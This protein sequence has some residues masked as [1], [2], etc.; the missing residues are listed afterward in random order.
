MGT[1]QTAGERVS[2][3]LDQ[4]MEL[5]EQLDLPSEE[6]QPIMDRAR[7][8][9][10][11]L[12]EVFERSQGRRQVMSK[13]EELL[14]KLKQQWG[15]RLVYHEVEG[16][17]RWEVP[18]DVSV[19][20]ASTAVVL[21]QD[22][23]TTLDKYLEVSRQTPRSRTEHEKLQ[24]LLGQL[25]RHISETSVEIG[26][27]L[28]VAQRLPAMSQPSPPAPAD[29]GAKPGSGGEDETATARLPASA[30]DRTEFP[31]RV[32]LG[33]A[34]G[35]PQTAKQQQRRTEVE[36]GPAA[37]PPLIEPRVTVEEVDPDRILNLYRQLLTI[38]DYAAA[39]W[40]T[41]AAHTLGLSALPPPW[42]LKAYVLGC[43]TA[44][45]PAEIG[46]QWS[47]IIS[48]HPNVIEDSLRGNRVDRG[49]LPLIVLGA[50][51]GPAL[52]GWGPSALLWLHETKRMAVWASDPIDGIMS[53]ARSGRPLL[54]LDPASWPS[55]SAAEAALR[56]R[57]WLE[58]GSDPGAPFQLATKVLRYFRSQKSI[59]GQLASLIALDDPAS[60]DRVRQLYSDLSTP[61]KQ[62]ELI[63]EAAAALASPSMRRTRIQGGLR[64][65]CLSA[66]RDI[67]E[68]ARAWIVATERLT[69]A[70]TAE[71]DST[72][73]TQAA[74]T[75][76]RELSDAFQ[77]RDSSRPQGTG[78]GLHAF[79]HAVETL[80]RY[81]QGKGP[82]H[83]HL[84]SWL[85]V[86]QQPVLVLD[87][88]PLLDEEA[89]PVGL[90]RLQALEFSAKVSSPR[91]LD[92]LARQHM[93]RLNFLA[94][95][96][97]LNIL[98]SE[99]PGA[100]QPLLEELESKRTE[101]TQGIERQIS[102]LRSAVERET[103]QHVLTE[104]QRS[105]LIGEA[106]E[107]LKGLRSKG[108]RL[109]LV[110]Q[111]VEALHKQLVDAR[112]T[113]KE[114]LAS[115][116]GQL[117][118]SLANDGTSVTGEELQ[119]VTSALEKAEL[120]LASDDLAVADERIT[121][122]EEAIHLGKPLVEVHVRE[123]ESILERFLQS[124]QAL[125]N[126]LE[127]DRPYTVRREIER[128]LREPP[129]KRPQVAGIDLRDVPGA[130]TGE[131]MNGLQAF[132]ELKGLQSR[133][134][135]QQAIAHH[136]CTLLEYYGFRHPHVR[137]RVPH[138]TDY[139]HATVQMSDG[140]LSPLSAFGSERQG[141]Y[142]VLL[143]WNRPSI[144][145]LEQIINELHLLGKA[146]IVIYL[147]RA[148]LR[149]RAE[150]SQFCHRQN[151]TAMFIDELVTFFV[152]SQRE[153]RLPGTVMLGI[154]WGFNNP[155]V[156]F[157]R[158]SV[159][160]EIFKGRKEIIEEL[161]KPL[162]SA[163]IYGGR[164]LG[165]SAI[166]RS[167]E[168]RA[169]EDRSHGH[170]LYVCYLDILN[171]GSPGS[172]THPQDVW[173]KIRQW[174]VEV[175]LL[176]RRVSER[177]EKVHEK[178]A[179][180]FTSDPLLRVYVLLDEADKFLTADAAYEFQ[181]V[182]QLKSLMD[183]T[184]GRF[185]VILSGLHSVQRF[186]SMPNQPLLHFGDAIC[187]G[188]LE[189]RAAVELIRVPLHALGYRFR[190]EDVVYRILS[191]TNYHPALIQ[192]FC[193]ELVR[194]LAQ[195]RTFVAQSDPRY[196]IT[197]EDV[198]QVYRLP[199]VRRV[200]KDRFEATLV[201]DASFE[202]IVYSMI[203]FQL[204]EPDGYRKEFSV[205]EVQELV[206]VTWPQ[207]FANVRHE[208]LRA[209]LDELVGL[210]VLL[211]TTHGSYRLRNANV[212]RALGFMEEIEKRVD[213]FAD[214][215]APVPEY[216]P[217]TTVTL[218][219]DEG[220][221]SPLTM[222]Q[223][224]VLCQP[225]TGVCLVFGS[226]ALG[227][228]HLP[229]ALRQFAGKDSAGRTAI[230]DSVAEA[231]PEVVTG[232]SLR[233]WL[234]S[235]WKQLQGN[236]LLVVVQADH[237]TDE[238]GLPGVVENLLRFVDERQYKS[239]NRL[240][241]LVIAFNSRATVGWMRDNPSQVKQIEN[242]AAATLEARP[243]SGG[244]MERFIRS[245]MLYTREIHLLLEEV[246]GGWPWLWAQ[247]MKTLRE[248]FGQDL[249]NVNPRASAE[250][251][252]AR[253]SGADGDLSKAFLDAT[254]LESVP[255]GRTIVD[256]IQILDGPPAE[257]LTPELVFANGPGCSRE[258]FWA[259]VESMLRLGLLRKTDGR[260]FADAV[261]AR[262]LGYRR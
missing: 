254:G 250:E 4:L 104:S 174:F 78:L 133:G 120:A 113:R 42:L 136:L 180:R 212:V 194:V 61:A 86:L 181:T 131:I 208:H 170:N 218:V 150:W 18:A 209:L 31:A 241:R 111:S 89:I 159:P 125:F 115:R 43:L 77:S 93:C 148:T 204:K 246:I 6:L 8:L 117:R 216:D 157:A 2:A 3:L 15:E 27:L 221:C 256:A 182:R 102:D 124:E 229:A 99:N 236:R 147:G 183:M 128:A 127:Q 230:Y 235:R 151:L 60:V 67:A 85:R 192:H 129:G 30:P 184:Q 238:R 178:L 227:I 167:I 34:P 106:E 72:R 169:R 222:K 225:R 166:L 51:V 247:L 135:T 260:I 94:A 23:A 36:D 126:A 108:G 203:W 9:V 5:A 20:A 195:R 29:G 68:I 11:K 56:A 70:S 53:L 112:R 119:K 245:A 202:A 206:S 201:L 97:A 217:E 168:R 75:L 116:I 249:T 244:V 91:Q 81:L 114:S 197:V 98:D 213:G 74:L 101:A 109:D 90:S 19:Q 82:P 140:G 79:N 28:G 62:N 237:L 92:V 191:Y 73:D 80:R 105:V 252:R 146:P 165:K 57:H 25:H 17:E 144:G 177:P 59:S 137:L 134:F 154:A 55:T 158:G 64:Q 14:G 232:E 240:L 71:S 48:E 142:E 13:L 138:G 16:W 35:K 49:D 185:K 228:Q 69:G 179:E 205:Q 193:H 12:E 258:E 46:S 261:V 220:H 83:A 118:E 122:V 253:T 52:L 259:S 141:N 189:A 210:G 39:Y 176:D 41:E 26:R 234:E 45:A 7:Q 219:D 87:D 207:A 65:R 121:Q 160:P 226:E 186:A 50:S 96:I 155:Y 164:Q 143:V 40:L 44:R 1:L 21:L 132:L 196:S 95:S 243:W 37:L 63:D 173:A 107:C 198:E 172:G 123:D 66:L 255:Y 175:D 215:P 38:G 199:D 58:L 214:R 24:E 33:E 47:D 187:V 188:P 171:V 231:P 130:R 242:K 149:Q 190:G 152:S 162:G 200:M 32:G 248:T 22:L 76:L 262:A 224:G 103:T 88:S 153:S 139:L 211:K 233:Q 163:I 100:A 257:D 239:R 161:W 54:P 223:E 156:P 84:S 110:Q 251:L 10:A 145:A